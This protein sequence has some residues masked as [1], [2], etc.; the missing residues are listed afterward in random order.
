LRNVCGPQWRV[1]VDPVEVWGVH[2]VNLSKNYAR[3]IAHIDPKLDDSSYVLGLYQ[4]AGLSVPAKP[5][6]SWHLNY[7]D[8]GLLDKETG[9]FF[10]LCKGPT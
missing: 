8:L 3:V 10:L 4:R 1:I 2:F 6:L 7:L 5:K 9:V